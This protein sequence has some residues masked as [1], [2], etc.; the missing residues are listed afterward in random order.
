MTVIKDKVED[1]HTGIN[2]KKVFDLTGG[3][4][5]FSLEEL[6]KLD[7]ASLANIDPDKIQLGTDLQDASIIARTF[8]R[9][10]H[11][12]PKEVAVYA[13]LQRRID[14]SRSVSRGF[15]SMLQTYA[16]APENS[17]SNQMNQAQHIAEKALR[18]AQQD[19][20]ADILFPSNATSS[21]KDGQAFSQSMA[22][23]DQDQVTDNDEGIGDKMGKW[24][25]DCIPCDLRLDSWLEMNP[26]VDLNGVVNA[27]KGVELGFLNSVGNIL[28]NLDIFGDFCA[29]MDLFNF[30][31]IPDL[32]RILFLLSTM[33][34]FEMPQLDGLIGLVAMLIAPLLTPILSAIMGLLDQFELLVANPL[35]CIVD[36]LNLQIE[37][38]PKADNPFF[39]KGDTRFGAEAARISGEVGS[40]LGSAVEKANVFTQSVGES[41]SILKNFIESAIELIREKIK[42]YLKDLRSLLNDFS[43][44]D[45]AYIGLALRKLQI[46][47]LSSF[48]GSLIAAIAS[49]NTGF[50]KGK[51]AKPEAHEIDNFYNNY[52]G[53]NL[54]FTVTV[55][56]DGD[57]EFVEKNYPEDL[58]NAQNVIEFEG[59]S[60]TSQQISQVARNLTEPIRVSKPCRLEVT[61]TEADTL[62]RY[63]SELNE[64]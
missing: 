24:V 5:A 56:D 14:N 34:A 7:P 31:C 46:V 13:V 2:A 22:V 59:E 26:G 50:C 4:K 60:I 32:Q 35:E 39:N 8:E 49:G 44:T 37:K 41:L 25:K 63:I 10:A 18:L 23:G 12:T 55:N 54:S 29:L 6:K 30:T 15:S 64:L 27:F 61:A 45:S 16:L 58:P 1:A 42:F 48:I 47:R 38:I 33:L 51:G 62:N 57:L 11:Y 9:G 19:E 40:E 52:L 28:N 3:D 43:G 36:A 17:V 21:A 53:P 20:A